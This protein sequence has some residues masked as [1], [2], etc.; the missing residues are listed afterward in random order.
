MTPAETVIDW[1]E[2]VLSKHGEGFHNKERS[3]FILFC[4]IYIISCILFVFYLYTQAKRTIDADLN[5]RLYYG[6]L[7]TSAVLGERYHDHLV[8]R[9]SKSEAEDWRSIQRLTAYSQK[10]D[11][12]YLY[13][14]IAR[15]GEAI[16][17][18]SSA[19]EDEL[20]NNTYVRFFDPYPDASPLLLQALH[21]N[22]TVWTDY[23]DHWGEFRA[24][25]VPLVSAD[26][27][28]YIA[29]AEVSMNKYYHQLHTQEL[30]LAGFSIFLFV[31]FSIFV[32]IYLTYIRK[33]LLRAR[34]HTTA[35]QE[36]KDASESANQAKSNFVAVMSHEIRTP[37]NG[38]LGAVELLSHSHLNEKQRE[39]FNIIESG[40]KSLLAIVSDVLEFSKIEANKIIFEPT[41][42]AL[43]P[44]AT[45]LIDLT[46]LQ[47]KSPNITLSCVIEDDVPAY[48]RT[49]G[50]KLQQIISNLLSNAA[51][52]T[53]TGEIR[54]VISVANFQQKERRLYVKVQ[55]TGIGI[56]PEHQHRLFH[57]FVQLE[58]RTGGTGLGL[59]ICKHLVEIMGGTIRV[60]SAPDTGTTFTLNIPYEL[61]PNESDVKREC[62]AKGKQP[63]YQRGTPLRILV[64]DD[65]LLN[66][67]LSR[68]M[69]EQ[70]GHTVDVVS[71][72][73]DVLQ[74]IQTTHYD[75][76]LMDIY[77]KN[78]DGIQAT[79]CIRNQME[80]KQPY[81][82]AYTANAC[83]ED[84]EQYKKCGM[85]DV[86][87][88]PI[89]LQ[90][91]QFVLKRVMLSKESTCDFV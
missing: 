68:L 77:M 38:V 52:F 55:D 72:G 40:G 49:D 53:D 67:S 35:M 23:Q 14:V 1:H 27:S 70:L 89:Q 12:T 64:V 43:E 37:L 10:M 60:D 76:I 47:L 5:D 78:M 65:S 48:I 59:S 28:K 32:A 61:T 8:N 34:L 3:K 71:D 85:D 58:S 26:G 15:H 7:M 46:R 57:P 24:V 81:I 74:A 25:F 33:N 11:L 69:L 18:S 13:T 31:D 62:I 30:Q 88:K 83:A 17:V 79:R 41:S 20:K 39:L 51:K 6:A 21:E 84:I 4:V 73:S 19:S 29:G 56:S 22:K 50:Q 66:Q 2:P 80:I 90:D 82:V 42:F 36:A 87:V 91:M 45:T 54:L 9:S 75:V 44:L 86:L 63:I 16:L